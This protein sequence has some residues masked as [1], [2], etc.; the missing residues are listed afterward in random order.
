VLYLKTKLQPLTYLF[1]FL[2]V[3]LGSVSFAF[4]QEDVPE[5]FSEEEIQPIQVEILASHDVISPGL[6][7]DLAIKLKHK[8]GWHT[9]WKNPGEVGVAIQIEWV[10]PEGFEIEELSWPTPKKFEEHGIIGYGYEE[11]IYLLSPIRAKN[12]LSIGEHVTLEAK[13]S[14]VAC[15]QTACHPGE[16]NLTLKMPIQE[17]P[18]EHNEN[19]VLIQHQ[20]ESHPKKVPVYQTK[21]TGGFIEM[22]LDLSSLEFSTPKVTF[23]PSAD[24]LIDTHSEPLLIRHEEKGKWWLVLRRHA[25]AINFS[26][27]NGVLLIQDEEGGKEKSHALDIQLSLPNA[28]T[29]ASGTLVS[30]VDSYHSSKAYDL[31]LPEESGLLVFLAMAFL[32]GIILNLMPCVLPV[33]SFKILSFVK[34]AGQNRKETLKHGLFFSGGVLTSFWILAI[35]LLGLQA[36]G[37]VVGWGFQLQEPLFV[38]ILAIVLFVFGLSLFGIFEFGTVVAS[39]AG[40]GEVKS[41]KN[42]SGYMGSFFSGVLATAVATPCTGPFLGPAVGFAVTKPPLVALFIF[43]F[44]GL[45]MAFPYLILSFFPSLLRFLPKPGNWMV[46]LKQ[47]T[48]FIMVATVIWLLWVFTAETGPDALFLLIGSLFLVSVACW[49]WG[50]WGTPLVTKKARYFAACLTLFLFLLSGKLIQ[51]SISIKDDE[52]SM[53]ETEKLRS[54]NSWEHFSQERV[55]KY[56]NEGKP[57]FID[58]TARWCLICQ[59]NHLV[60]TR[61]E[62]VNKFDSLNIVRMKADWTRHDASIT[63]ELAKYGRNGVPLYLLYP[64]KGKKPIILPQVLTPEGVLAYLE[65]M[66]K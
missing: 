42:V 22:E 49:V 61:P 36:Y 41:L 2:A 27:I 59:A 11:E 29:L 14:W 57:V 44:L 15:S 5:F 58:F 6:H 20:K 55:E 26:S 4:S 34:M 52:I 3:C 50:R 56:L 18:N 31:E 24:G 21:E 7:F 37:H 10:L 28:A 23:L 8:T 45:G 63:Q 51:L 30:L 12:N 35:L 65:E 39:F 32:G 33:I 47:L 48:G 43:T 38:A 40:S 1:F 53:A 17:N 25:E 16:K 19:L 13:V 9:Y 62:V 66:E 64:G 60:L 54:S 46:A